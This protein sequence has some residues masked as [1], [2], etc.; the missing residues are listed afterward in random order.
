M[1]NNTLAA[2]IVYKPDFSLGKLVD[3]LIIQN[4]DVFLFINRGNRIA[5][6]I[7]KSKKVDYFISSENVGIS[8]AFNKVIK[9]FQ[10]KGYKYLFTFDQDSLIEN[11]FISSMISN[12]NLAQKLNKNVVC[13][14]PTIKDRKYTKS[15][16]LIKTSRNYLKKYEKVSFAITSGSLY[17]PQSFEKVGVMNELLF[18]DG[19]DVDWCERANLNNFTIIKSRNVFLH[20]KIGQKYINFFGIKKSFHDDNLR[21]YYIVRNSI[22]LILR[23]SNSI[24]WKIIQVIKTPARLIG[25][26]LLSKNLKEAI[27]FE[28]FAIR[29]AIN[30]D[31][32]KMKYIKH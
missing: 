17:T 9:I 24:Q 29:D 22:Y 12:F 19:V 16:S 26:A 7:I 21:V 32:E 4:V 11:N 10:D 23:G 1:K 3:D 6:K 20:H 2:I 13:C 28:F 30:G 5:N 25:Y 15:K 27:R 8:K 31:M 14:A 18:I